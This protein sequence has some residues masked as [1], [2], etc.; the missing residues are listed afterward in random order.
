MHD[1]P[2]AAT[3][4]LVPLAV[5]LGGGAALG[6]GV[7]PEGRRHRYG[8]VR[9]RGVKIALVA[10]ITTA[11]ATSG[12]GARASECASVPVMVAGHGTR[13]VCPEDVAAQRLT[14]VDLSDRW[15]PRIFSE[16]PEAPQPY[17]A[18][19]LALAREH[20]G[21]GR[22]STASRDDHDLELYGIFPDVSV[23]RR[24]LLDGERHACHARIDDAG[25]RALRRTVA[26]WDAL[27]RRRPGVTAAITVVQ[28]HL[29]C[30]GLV[31]GAAT[32][33][34]FDAPTREAL[35]AYQRRHMLPSA[36]VLDDETR[37]TLLTNSREL[38][39]RSLLRVLRE[40]VVDATGLIEDGSA[41]NAWE[42]V[43]GRFIDSAEYRHV[44]R[45]APLAAGAPDLVDRATATAAEAL[46]WTSPEAAMSAL[47]TFEQRSV[48]VDLP[49]VPS[50]HT[51]PVQLRAE[52]DRGDVSKAYP[53]DAAGHPRSSSV[54]N[55]PTFVLF[56]TTEHG[57]IP[58]VRWGTTIGSWKAEKEDGE[59]HLAYKES[60]VG[61]RYWRELLVAPT[62]LPPETTPDRE[63]VHRDGRGWVADV[64][65]VGP[66]Y[67]S[68]YGLVALPHLRA[69]ESHGAVEYSD[70]E[71]RTHGSGN[72]RSILRGA[73]H[74]CHRL[75]N[76]LAIRLGSFLL[77]HHE[78]K[79]RGLV[80]AHY[81]RVLRW[82]GHASILRVDSRG[83]RY[84]LV[85]PVE[86]DVLRG[87]TLRV[88]D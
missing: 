73:S 35:A 63:L 32:P 79:R 47:E 60:P 51:Q 27:A 83:Y 1:L 72:Y 13:E 46:G 56:A 87:R 4:L 76:H 9:R 88:R 41:V 86:V 66:G 25:L 29:V 14:I 59:E 74:G 19:V 52:I 70:T 36:A 6:A 68:A 33:G 84:E 5:A 75:F 28:R 77:A 44:L 23:V 31:H 30:E 3:W 7:I 78:F 57:E 69:S 54:K 55:R 71:I 61:R 21:E 22:T 39:F 58:L 10:A 53:F 67:R 18:T 80:A 11:A 24:R 2:T 64:E 37:A 26:P 15:A 43:L 17:R 42:P 85:P 49:Q 62:W 40:R 12:L 48:A 81:R 34:V 38:D 16:T 82:K 65:A 45:P 8:A 20:F 50:Y